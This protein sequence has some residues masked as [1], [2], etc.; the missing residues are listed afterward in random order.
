RACLGARTLRADLVTREL[1]ESI[2]EESSYYSILNSKGIPP[3]GSHPF[4]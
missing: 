2:G 1:K 3:H 4:T